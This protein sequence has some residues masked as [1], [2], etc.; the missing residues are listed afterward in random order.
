MRTLLLN[1]DNKCKCQVFSSLSHIFYQF[2]EVQ[3]RV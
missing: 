1:K 2:I 3:L